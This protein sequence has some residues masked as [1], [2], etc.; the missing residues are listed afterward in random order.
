MTFSD[1]ESAGSGRTNQSGTSQASSVGASGYYVALTAEMCGATFHSTAGGANAFVCLQVGCRRP[2][3]HAGPRQGA[4]GAAYTVQRS[5]KGFKDGVLDSEMPVAQYL[6]LLAREHAEDAAALEDYDGGDDEDTLLADLTPGVPRSTS[7]WARTLDMIL[8]EKEATP[9][10]PAPM[11]P[12]SDKKP[13]AATTRS[14]RGGPQGTNVHFSSPLSGTAQANVRPAQLTTAAVQEAKLADLRRQ[15]ELLTSQMEPPPVEV[16]TPPPSAEEVIRLQAQQLEDM[17]TQIQLLQQQ[18]SGPSPSRPPAVPSVGTTRR[19]AVKPVKSVKPPK[20]RQ[21]KADPED[22]PSS[23]PP[24]SDDSL[25]PPKEVKKYWY[26]VAFGKWGFDGVFDDKEEARALL[27]PATSKHLKTRSKAEAWAFVHFHRAAR[28]AKDSPSPPSPTQAP[29]APIPV[30]PE[31]IP[32]RADAGYSAPPYVLTGKDTSVK[33]KEKLFGISL[34][35]SVEEL[36]AQL[37]PPGLTD[38]R[39]RDTMELLLDAVSLPGKT[40]HNAEAEDHQSQMTDSLAELASLGRQE[41][42]GDEIRRDLKWKQSN[43]NAIRC[44]KSAE[45]L[46]EIQQNVRSLR[47]ETLRN[48]VSSQRTILGREPWSQTTIDSWATGGY[49]SVLS[50]HSLDHYI[51]LLQHLNTVSIDLGWEHAKREIDFYVKKWELIRNNSHSRLLALCRIYITLRDGAEMEWQ[52][53]KLEGEKVT[54]LLKW[55]ASVESATGGGGNASSNLFCTKCAT[56]LHGA[57]G[58]PWGNISATKAKQKARDVLKSL[59]AGTGGVGGEAPDG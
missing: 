46:L 32:P 18:R 45:D 21:R 52:S 30:A 1:D 36:R 47:E 12:S 25:T 53:T 22:S 26:G 38:G 4:I 3:H 39:A 8:G 42:S 15:M 55:K 49:V 37:A 57:S 2:N 50:R 29:S 7:P 17:A 31:P 5:T 28:T 54:S 51:N 58:C 11:A 27:D 43:R 41:V 19:A 13:R 44:V 40:S 59:G 23:S 16:P 56:I 35:M 6:A 9:P 10:T 48:I 20:P 14:K 24:D 33:D 34:D